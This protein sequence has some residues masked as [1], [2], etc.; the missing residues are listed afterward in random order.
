V[1][2][3]VCN[4]GVL[5]PDEREKHMQRWQ[6]LLGSLTQAELLLAG[7]RLTFPLTAQRLKLLAEI[8]SNERLCCPFLEFAVRLSGGHDWLMLEL[9]GPQGTTELLAAELGLQA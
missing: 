1:T 2:N 8:I 7:W 6:N 5:P 9:T 3:L 4:I